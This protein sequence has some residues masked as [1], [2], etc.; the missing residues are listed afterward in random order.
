[1]KKTNIG[2]AFTEVLIQRC[3][4]EVAEIGSELAC[5]FQEV[6]L[7]RDEACR[8]AR[9]AIVLR[10]RE[11]R[12]Q[13]DSLVSIVCAP[14]YKPVQALVDAMEL[15]KCFQTLCD[16]DYEAW[17]Q[18]LSEVGKEVDLDPYIDSEAFNVY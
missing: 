3:R 17:K 1:M 6:G 9:A 15:P 14:G 18:F 13:T 16:A 5:D 7:E 4:E 8:H 12:V 10:L 11:I 2:Q